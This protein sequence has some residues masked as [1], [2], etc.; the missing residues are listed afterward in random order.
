MRQG[1]SSSVALATAIATIGCSAA[2]VPRVRADAP[3]ADCSIHRAA[4]AIDTSMAVVGGGVVVLGAGVVVTSA[5]EYMASLGYAIGAAVIGV[6]LIVL[7]P[8]AASASYGRRQN[9]RCWAARA[10]EAD[11]LEA[12]ERVRGV[13]SAAFEEIRSGR[14]VSALPLPDGCT[15]ADVERAFAPAGSPAVGRIGRGHMRERREVAPWTAGASVS[16]WL[17]EERVL[18]LEI[19]QPTLPGPWPE[20]RDDLG[21]P[22]MRLDGQWVYAGRGLAVFFAEDDTVDRIL[23]FPRTTVAGYAEHYTL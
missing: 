17:V 2:I 18:A 1:V 15:L 14:A 5:D 22:D 16:V 13:C 4:P 3:A 8:Y 11:E 21:E 9:R 7:A 19:A 6:G 10:A 20:V 23:L 12:G